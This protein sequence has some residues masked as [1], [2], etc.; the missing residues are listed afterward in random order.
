MTPLQRRSAASRKGA[1]TRAAMKALRASRETLI[2]GDAAQ[3]CVCITCADD[4]DAKGRATISGALGKAPG[5]RFHSPA[6]QLSGPG[7]DTQVGIRDRS[8]S[9]ARDGG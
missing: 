6:A 4:S 8:S 7:P 9:L 3:Q 5:T 2:S 1:R